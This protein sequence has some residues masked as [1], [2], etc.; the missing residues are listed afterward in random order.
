MTV[1][2][3]STKVR[4]GEC[5]P[6]AVGAG[7]A[8]PNSTDYA[9][10]TLRGSEHCQ[11]KLHPGRGQTPPYAPAIQLHIGVCSQWVAYTSTKRREIEHYT[12]ASHTQNRNQNK[13]RIP[14]YPATRHKYTTVCAGSE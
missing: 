11:L 4:S 14:P 8:G 13:E 7:T 12:A 3:H 6:F 1:P 9:N 2:C 5:S 10:N